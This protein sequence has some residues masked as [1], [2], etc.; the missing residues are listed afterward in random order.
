[1]RQPIFP[2]GLAWGQFFMLKLVRTHFTARH[3]RPQI[4][5]RRSSMLF[6]KRWGH[7]G[8]VVLG[9][10]LIVTSANAQLP[11]SAP[12]NI[13]NNTDSSTIPQTAV[14]SSGNI[15]AV[16][17]DDTSKN[18]LFSRSSDG[19]ATFSTAI[20]LSSPKSFPSSPRIAVDANDGINVIWTDT[21]S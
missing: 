15:F 17:E 5:R 10:V 11:F 21:L 2:A 16:W 8:S 18:V 12:K 19:G 1:S 6:R 14:D 9:F 4:P 3:Y 20:S 7:F 13:S